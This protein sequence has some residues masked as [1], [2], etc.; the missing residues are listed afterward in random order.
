[1]GDR[2]GAGWPIGASVLARGGESAG[3]GQSQERGGEDADSSHGWG[4]SG[5]GKRVESL[6]L[7]P[8]F[9]N[10][11]EH[12]T[13]RES[14]AGAHL[15]R[16]EAPALER[17][18]RHRPI[19]RAFGFQHQGHAAPSGGRTGRLHL[20]DAAHPMASQRQAIGPVFGTEQ[21]L[22]RA[23]RFSVDRIGEQRI[24]VAHHR[25]RAALAGVAEAGVVVVRRL[26]V[27]VGA[28]L[29]GQGFPLAELS[30]ATHSAHFHM[31]VRLSVLPPSSG[32]GPRWKSHIFF[33]FSPVPAIL[34]GF[35][36][37]GSGAVL[38]PATSG[39]SSA[40]SAA[41][42]PCCGPWPGGSAPRGKA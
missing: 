18:Q 14:V 30:P 19:A 31:P 10:A 2:W 32:A 1:M 5:L 34:S 42:R 21:P 22:E 20:P 29:A 15:E 25:D 12:A 28:V 16:P 36:G 6:H 33:M 23:L 35:S 8:D 27:R 38:M 26:G 3:A 39:A 41:P 13:Q 4:L 11:P 7:C 24:A 17:E 37:G 40:R 9:A